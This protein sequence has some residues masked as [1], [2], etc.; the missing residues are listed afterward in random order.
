M[1]QT[2]GGI[3]LAGAG[4]V[5]AAGPASARERSLSAPV[6][7]SGDLTVTWHGD[8][9]RGCARAGLCDY[10]GSV[11]VHPG[12]SDGDLELEAGAGPSSAFGYVDSIARPVIRVRRGND[13]ACLDF[14]DSADFELV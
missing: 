14:T 9:A 8:R 6:T 13:G 2:V 11:E 10:R 4:L 3:T 5:A 7:A 12:L 1:R